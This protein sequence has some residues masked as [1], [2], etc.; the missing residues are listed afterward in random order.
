[1]LALAAGEQMV[2]FDYFVGSL[3]DKIALFLMTII[4]QSWPPAVTVEG[5]SGGREYSSSS[6]LISRLNTSARL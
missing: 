1:M 3:Q 4:P 6:V 5:I 2:F